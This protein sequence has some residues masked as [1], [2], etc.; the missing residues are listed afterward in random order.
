MFLE[1]YVEFMPTVPH[2]VQARL[3][4]RVRETPEIP[5]AA[6]IG[7][8]SGI[9]AND[10]YAMRWSSWENLSMSIAG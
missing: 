5:L 9:R 1:D 7:D 3:L 8:E 10:V 6:V 2:A 4:E